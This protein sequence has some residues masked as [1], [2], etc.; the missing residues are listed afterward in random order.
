MNPFTQMLN[1]GT[2]L[3]FHIHY[4]GTCS[5][6]AGCPWCKE[7]EDRIKE[8]ILKATTEDHAALRSPKG[9]TTVIA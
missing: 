8:L 3:D 4:I 5:N 2:A 9:F 1:L 7:T 6:G